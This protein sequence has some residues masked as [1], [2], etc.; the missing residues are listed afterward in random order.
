MI[1]KTIRDKVIKR[2]GYCLHCGED[3]AISINHRKNRGMGGSKNLDRLDNLVVVCSWLNE[4]MEGSAYFR[5][6]GVEMGW[7]LLQF[8]DFSEPVFDACT[9]VWYVLDLNGGREEVP[10]PEEAL[11]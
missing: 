4:R 5:E 6:Y 9:G 7:K 1:S 3:E 10:A 11:F 8:Q 2:D